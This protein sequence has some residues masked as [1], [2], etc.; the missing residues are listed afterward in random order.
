MKIVNLLTLCTVSLVLTQANAQPEVP[1]GFK[2]G[3]LILADNSHLSG[4]IKDNIRSNASVLFIAEASEKKKTYNGSDL[5]SA[6][7]EGTKFIC[8][9]GDFFKVLSEGELNF[10]Q[11]AS[12]A[13]GKPV[14]NGNEAIFSNG[15][16][17]KPNDY[18]IYTAGSKQLNLVSKKN[19]DEVIAASFAGYT[20][21]IDKAK[22]VNGDLSQLKDAVEIY[23]NRNR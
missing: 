17:G 5:N 14:Y 10:L 20:A 23:N 9:K 16:E 22:T 4:Y 7:I 8:I 21:A 6:E 11:K 19:V 13:S 18:F 15:T 12:D 1:K 2:K 3:A